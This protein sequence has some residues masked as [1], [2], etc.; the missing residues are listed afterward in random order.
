MTGRQ[1]PQGGKRTVSRRLSPSTMILENR[2]S[3]TLE[4]DR[5]EVSAQDI[6][7]Q[8][9]RANNFFLLNSTRISIEDVFRY[10]GLLSAPIDSGALKYLGNSLEILE[11]AVRQPFSN[12]PIFQKFSKR[13]PHSVHQNLMEALDR[14]NQLKAVAEEY[15]PTAEHQ[16]E[17]NQDFLARALKRDG[18]GNRT[19]AIGD[20]L[21]VLEAADLLGGTATLGVTVRTPADMAR[22]VQSGLPAGVIEKLRSAG[23]K[24]TELTVLIAP[25]RTLNRRKTDGRFTVEESSRIEHLARILALSDRTFGDRRLALDW[26]RRPQDR[27]SGQSPMDYL[28][29]DIGGRVVEEIL[30][31]SEYGIFG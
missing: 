25:S 2:E 26:L 11:D 10:S 20:D 17:S 22:L 9:E 24:Q 14:L 30:I 4:T 3:S 28:A 1:K 23:F 6:L 16:T 18:E 12:N 13:D 15:D 21:P 19:S 31:Q 27:L 29:S 5:E 7:D 8:I